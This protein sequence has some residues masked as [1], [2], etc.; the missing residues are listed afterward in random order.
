MKNKI[1]NDENNN[2]INEEK[3]L[4]DIYKNM[5][6]PPPIGKYTKELNFDSSLNMSKLLPIIFKNKNIILGEGAFS[7]VQLYQD[8]KTKIKYAVK[9][10]NLAHLEKLSQN[11]KFVMNEVNIQGRISHPNIIKLYNFFENNKECNLILEYASKGTLYD[12][13][14]SNKGLNENIAFC[15]FLQTLNAIYFL[16]LHSIIHRDLK[17]E[18]LL[19]NENNIIKLCD[20]GWSVKLKSNKRTTFCGTVEYMAPEIIK[21]QQYDETIDIWSLGVLLYELVHSYSPFYSEDSDFKKIKN[22]IVQNELIFKEGLSEDY[23]DLIKKILIKDSEKRIKI[24]EIYQHPF[25]TKHINTLYKELNSIST[26]INSKFVKENNKKKIIDNIKNK[27]LNYNINNCNKNNTIV[28]G[29]DSNKNEDIKNNECLNKNIKFSKKNNTNLNNTN[30]NN[31]IKNKLLINRRKDLDIEIDNNK[32][33]ENNYIFDSIPTEP[34]AKILPDSKD[35]QKIKKINTNINIKKNNN[36]LNK[37]K[38][39]YNNIVMNTSRNK[40]ITI[41]NPKNQKIKSLC[42][43][44]NKI[45]HVKSFSLG[46]NNLNYSELKN[47]KLKIIISINNTQN[48]NYINK[49]QNKNLISKNK[50][51]ISN[52]IEHD[53]LHSPSNL[54]IYKKINPLKKLI[55]CKKKSSSN[56]KNNKIINQTYLREDKN[57]IKNDINP[58]NIVKYKEIDYYENPLNYEDN[59]NNKRNY[60]KNISYIK[61]NYIKTDNNI[62]STSPYISLINTSNTNNISNIIINNNKNSPRNIIKPKNVF[63]LKKIIKND[64]LPNSSIKDSKYLRR[65]NSNSYKKISLNNTNINKSS[66]KGLNDKN[67]NLDYFINLCKNNDNKQ[68]NIVNIH[69][70][71][72]SNIIQKLFTK[73]DKIDLNKTININDTKKYKT[74]KNNNNSIQNNLTQNIDLTMINHNII[75][76][77]IDSDIMKLDKSNIIK[78]NKSCINNKKIISFSKSNKIIIKTLI[79]ENKRNYSKE[80]ELTKG[81]TEKKSLRIIKLKPKGINN[82]KNNKK[83]IKIELNE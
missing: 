5:L 14:I 73:N 10:M 42:K 65:I 61:D 30:L 62:T 9:K 54:D 27:Y 63:Q 38:N 80:K 31:K 59:K 50:K 47:N 48:K 2:E 15:Y 13:I 55:N 1:I 78:K 64:K 17:P 52:L 72:K 58:N 16:H 46:L 11:K 7:K 82:I 18:N 83:T 45:S 76:N 41:D 4:L 81:K 66:N 49:N 24:E 60:I 70:N 23:K 75:N 6:Y 69:K 51:T 25:I 36:S 20:F 53:Y 12:L 68:L 34:E 74:V 57:S 29:L 33:I 43:N 67:K 21:K 71:S 8:K 3:L 32:N 35:Y 28:Y 37:L 77:N 40:K 79:E 39:E 44:Q 19:I 56:N 26:S 22:N